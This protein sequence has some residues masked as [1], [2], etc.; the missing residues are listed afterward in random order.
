MPSPITPSDVLE[1]LPQPVT[2]G[3]QPPPE[4]VPVKRPKPKPLKAIENVEPFSFSVPTRTD[5]G[6]RDEAMQRKASAMNQITGQD[7][8]EFLEKMAAEDKKKWK[9]DDDGGRSPAEG[10][11]PIGKFGPRA[12]SKE[13][14]PPKKRI[15]NTIRSE[16]PV[17][18]NGVHGGWRHDKGKTYIPYYRGE[19]HDDGGGWNRMMGEW[20]RSEEK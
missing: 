1:Q 16:G 18:N 14:W 12:D 17:V 13:Y 4:E 6:N 5:V 9:V 11:G 19:G 15:G 8:G 7:V 10:Y 20:S 3:V 2:P